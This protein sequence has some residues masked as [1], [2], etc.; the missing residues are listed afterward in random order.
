MHV[1][2]SLCFRMGYRPGH[3]TAPQL[4]M[5]AARQPV[6]HRRVPRSAVFP[7]QLRFPCVTERLGVA[8]ACAASTPTMCRPPSLDCRQQSCG[9]PTAK[10]RPAD[11]KAAA[12]RQQSCGGLPDHHPRLTFECIFC[13]TGTPRPFSAGRRTI[14]CTGPGIE[15]C[16]VAPC[17]APV[18][19][20]RIAMRCSR[21]GTAEIL[22][23]VFG[24][25][26]SEG[27]NSLEGAVNPSP[28]ASSDRLRLL[29]TGCRLR[30]L[31]SISSI[32]GLRPSLSEPAGGEVG[33][34]AI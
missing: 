13:L 29:G 6:R 24:A 25:G 28:G 20:R 18:P 2:R 12:C 26:M 3:E 23:K 9:L 21:C 34:H 14:F 33:R 27:E 16:V 7:A 10:L 31:T 1:C 15:L 4:V 19:P 32:Y 17:Q 11:S 8:D 5:T 30:S 22:S